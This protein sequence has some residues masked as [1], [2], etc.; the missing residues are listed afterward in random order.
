MAETAGHLLVLEHSSDNAIWAEIGGVTSCS[1]DR[2][3]NLIDITS[4][5]DATAAKVRINGLKDGKIEMSGNLFLS[6]TAQTA[7]RASLADLVVDYLR[8]KFNGSG[9]TY[10]TVTVFLESYGESAGVGDAVTWNA[11]FKFHG[12]TLA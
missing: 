4:I 7:I 3:V 8:V 12:S 1:F 6:D 9:G 10:L 11:S 2:D 5:Q